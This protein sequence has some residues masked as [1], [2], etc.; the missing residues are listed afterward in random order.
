MAILARQVQ[1][2]YAD[3]WEE[4]EAFD[5]ENNAVEAKYGFPP[6][7]RY[8]MMSGPDEMGTLI[9]E[10]QWE[11]LAAMEEAYN[12]LMVDPVFQELGKRGNGILRDNRF[13]L[14]IIL[15]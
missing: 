12:K 7:K 4:L 5:K 13:E 3:K 8:Q 6:K 1:H 10:Y 2:I 14:Y 9:V 11:S 15:P